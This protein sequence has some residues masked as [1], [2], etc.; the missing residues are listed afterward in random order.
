MP[1]GPGGAAPSTGVPPEGA[2]HSDC[3]TGPHPQPP[4]L[5]SA[6]RG[7][8]APAGPE[9]PPD[10]NFHFRISV[11]R[12]RSVDSQPLCQLLAAFCLSAPDFSLFAHPRNG[13]GL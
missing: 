3:L 13:S 7:P 12:G 1:Q 2:L 4:Q 6:V 5:P 9:M 8:Q 11:T 10:C